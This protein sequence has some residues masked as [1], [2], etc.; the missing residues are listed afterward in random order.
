[1]ALPLALQRIGDVGPH[2]VG[3]G[4]RGE[5]ELPEAAVAGRR[6]ERVVM[7]VGQRL[8]TNPV[9]LQDERLCVDHA[10]QAIA[11]SGATSRANSWR[12]RSLAAPGV[13]GC[14]YATGAGLTGAAWFR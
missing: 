7:L 6:D 10:Q 1:V 2:R 13:R 11:K 12:E 5:P 4:D 8:E 14:G 3:R 9:S